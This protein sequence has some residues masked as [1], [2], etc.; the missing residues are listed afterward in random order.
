MREDT[1]AIGIVRNDVTFPTQ[2]IAIGN[3]AFQS[4]WAPWW[5]GL[6]ANADLSSK[7]ITKPIGKTSGAIVIDPSTIDRSKKIFGRL[8]IIA[9]NRL[10]MTLAIATDVIQGSIHVWNHPH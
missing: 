10:R 6:S 1:L 9:D 7:A 3:K 2:A 5:Q 8:F 4:N